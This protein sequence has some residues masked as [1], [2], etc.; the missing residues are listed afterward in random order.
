M[1][2]CS[3]VG[4]ALQ[5]VVRLSPSGQL[6]ATAGTDGHVRVWQFPSLKL[7]QDIVAHH[8]EIDDLDFAPDNSAVTPDV[9]FR[10][11][12]QSDIE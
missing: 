5:R 9:C 8:K 1:S 6:M 4:E 10:C 3:P 2:C 12:V 11:S 7:A